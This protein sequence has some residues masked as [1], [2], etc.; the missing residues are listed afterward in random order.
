M[1]ASG[2]SKHHS[3]VKAIVS[4]TKSFWGVI[5]RSFF[6]TRKAEKWQYHWHRGERARTWSQEMCVFS[7]HYLR[8]LVSSSPYWSNRAEARRQQCERTSDEP[9]PSNL[10]NL[11]Q[12]VCS[13]FVP[14]ILTPLSENLETQL[15]WS[16]RYQMM[17]WLGRLALPEK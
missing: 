11:Q 4:L 15:A 10:R 7:C 6:L 17:S 9:I 12:L 3:V 16:G 2:E 5:S 1:P 13:W 14:C 8:P